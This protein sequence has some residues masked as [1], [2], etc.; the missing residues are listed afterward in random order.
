MKEQ[1]EKK[2]SK[3]KGTR[4]KDLMLNLVYENLRRKN[5]PSLFY[6][7]VAYKQSYLTK[8]FKD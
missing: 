6:L 4:N 3:D 2:K 7:L 1:G 8:N 5:A